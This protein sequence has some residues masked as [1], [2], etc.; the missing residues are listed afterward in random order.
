MAEALAVNLALHRAM[1]LGFTNIHIASDF[2][3]LI[4]AIISET[5]SKELHGILHNILFISAHIHL[6]SFSFI[7][8]DLNCK[9]DALAKNSLLLLYLD[10]SLE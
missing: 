8:K 10:L 7:F 3:Q 4:K 5:P 1:D 9:A 2:Q 6:V